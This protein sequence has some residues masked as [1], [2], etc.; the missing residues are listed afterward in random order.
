MAD[1]GPLSHQQQ[2]VWLLDRLDPG[3]PAYNVPFAT[4]LRGRLDR[5]ALAGALTDLAERHPAL[6]T[7]IVEDGEEPVM[8]V[9]PVPGL[10]L[11]W[12]PADTP[13]AALD[14]AAEVA[15]GR[16]DLAAGRL[17]VAEVIS[18]PADRHLL[19]LVVHHIVCDG[20]AGATLLRDLGALYT[21]RATGV[22]ADLPELAVTPVSHA[23]AQRDALSGRRLRDHLDFWTGHLAGAPPVLDLP[24]D[25]PRPATGSHAGAIH[26]FTLDAGLTERVRRFARHQRITPFLVLYTAFGA[27]LHRYGGQDRVVVGFPMA[28]RTEP[29][30]E[31]LVA[32][33]ANVLPVCLDFSGD[34]DLPAVLTALRARL[35][36]V[37][38]FQDVPVPALVAELGVPRDLA[39][40]PLFQ[41]HFALQWFPGEQ[42]EFAGLELTRVQLDNRTSKF[43][44]Y[45]SLEWAGDGLLGELQYDSDLFTE[46]RA[47]RLAGHYTRLLDAAV[48]TGGTVASLPLLTDGER[49]TLLRRAGTG[50]GDGGS[51]V[52]DAFATRAA[53]D[54]GRVAV[55]DGARRL[56]FGEVDVLA[57]RLAHRLRRAGVGPE[58]VVGVCLRRSADQIVA[59]LG[60][61]KAGGAYLPL[62]PDHPPERVAFTVRDSGVRTVVTDTGTRPAVPPG[63]SVLDLDDPELA[64]EPPTPVEHGLCRD[65]LMTVVYTSGSSGRPK[66]VLGTHRNWT[67]QVAAMRREFPFGEDEVC[68]HKT[69]TAFVDAVWE[70]LDP[71]LHGVPVVVLPD[72]VVKDPEAFVA[73]LAHHRVTRLVAVPSLLGTLP[74]T[75]GELPHLTLCVSS[76]EELTPATARRLLARLPAARLVN[77]YGTTEVTADVTRYTVLAEAGRVGIGVPVPG[78]Q[79]HLLDGS[80]GLVPDG[81][82]G[83][84]HVGGEV[85]ARGYLGAPGLTAQRFVPSPFGDGERLYRTGDLGRHRPDG[86]I[87]LLGRADR[88]VKIRGVRV[89]PGEVRDTVAGFPAVAGCEVVVRTGLGDHQLVAYVCPAPGTEIDAAA[90]DAHLR[91][92]LPR[93]LLP[94]VVPLPELPLLPT[95]KVDT[96]ALEAREVLE[97][98]RAADHVAPRSR[99][100]TVMADIWRR[101]LGVDRVGVHDNFFDLGGDSVRALRLVALANQEGFRLRAQDPVRS[102]TVAELV[103]AAR[104][105]PAPAVPEL[106]VADADLRS[107][108]RLITRNAD[109]RDA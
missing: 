62:D 60:V 42:P 68:C 1:R 58:Q 20:W 54:P 27:L 61:L 77:L 102:Q 29:E 39:V 82:S 21:A 15:R 57:N 99:E 14:R 26:R 28:N 44:L 41:V 10:P 72:D 51:L 88:Q 33:L 103:A 9:S 79:V 63:P 81:S 5:S 37:Y 13:D 71:L 50:R 49:E 22:P 73:A 101:V 106:A 80:L 107:L 4:W 92:R 3:N 65:N 45:L 90:L 100:E 19:V 89:E 76:G 12:S 84:V 67:T 104:P 105:D 55:V 96:A 75:P 48:T 25:A 24:H 53:A 46:A 8:V 30:L 69:P 11:A 109:A 70:V 34:P 93:H 64:G 86:V 95:G 66:G 17:A 78:A 35:N 74:D 2:R 32:Y 87:E 38:E 108:T 59:M 40:A 7:A 43:D 47:A 83:E 94:T 56:T 18:L 36:A 85:V 98:L 91:A 31:P 52:P 23:R 97:P 6:R 16:L